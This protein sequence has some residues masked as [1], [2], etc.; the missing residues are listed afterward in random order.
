MWKELGWQDLKQCHKELCLALFYKIVHGLVAVPADDPHILVPA[1]TRT[2]A[3]HPYKYWAIPA[4]T[5]QFRNSFFVQTTPEWNQ[6]PEDAVVSETVAT[7]KSKIKI[8]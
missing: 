2:R 6:L 1:D 4:E 3:N 7:F 8:V 5:S